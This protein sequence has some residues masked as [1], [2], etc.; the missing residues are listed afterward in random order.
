MTQD[1][2][3]TGLLVPFPC[4]I[5]QA[6]EPHAVVGDILLAATYGLAAKLGAP[7]ATVSCTCIIDPVHSDLLSIPND[8]AMIPQ[9]TT[10]LRA[11]MVGEV[12]STAFGVSIALRSLSCI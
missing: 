12:G 8:P 1:M 4:S 11:P 5:T 2:H 10:G 9:H 6:F 7:F 3:P